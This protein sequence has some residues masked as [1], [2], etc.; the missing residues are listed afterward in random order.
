MEK[1]RMLKIEWGG[2]HELGDPDA[3]YNGRHRRSQRS[4]EFSNRPLLLDDYEDEND[5]HTLP[6]T[7]STS[8]SGDNSSRQETLLYEQPP[9]HASKSR[10]ASLYS[11]PSQE[12]VSFGLAGEKSHHRG[13]VASGGGAYQQHA[14]VDRRVLVDSALSTSRNRHVYE[15]YKDVLSESQ[16][17]VKIADLGNACWTVTENLN[18]FD[19]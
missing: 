16:L 7:S 13:R 2:N 8:S 17:Q 14:P 4:D 11:S 15:A 12:S 5:D 19:N 6:T 10:D 9:N 3:H 18:I 1:N